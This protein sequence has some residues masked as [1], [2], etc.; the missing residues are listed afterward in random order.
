MDL[1]CIEEG[2]FQG[3]Q[4]RV[5]LIENLVQILHLLDDK[6]PPPH[7]RIPSLPVPRASKFKSKKFPS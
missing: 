4:Y 1:H 3:L 6:V 5:I 7:T 2:E